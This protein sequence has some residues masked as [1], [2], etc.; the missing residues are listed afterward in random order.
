VRNI[1]S[2]LASRTYKPDFVIAEETIE[3]VKTHIPYLGY[4]KYI[5]GNSTCIISFLPDNGFLLDFAPAFVPNNKRIILQAAGWGMKFVPIFGDYL[6]QLAVGKMTSIP[7][8]FS[9]TKP[10]RLIETPPSPTSTVPIIV[11]SIFC[12]VVIILVGIIVK[13]VYSR[14]HNN[15]NGRA[16]Y[17]Q[18]TLN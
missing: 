8:E 13:L 2:D 14:N 9:I 11:S 17:N 10:G 5:I 18:V 7:P 4:D 12:G 3:F 6:A 1:L 15:T 16:G